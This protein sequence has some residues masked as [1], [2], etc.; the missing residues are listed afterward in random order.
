ML[1]KVQVAGYLSV[2]VRR[3]D[4]L[5]RADPAFPAPRLLSPG[6]ARWRRVDIDRWV[7]GLRA[8]WCTMGGRRAGAFGRRASQDGRDTV[9]DSTSSI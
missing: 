4:E 3:V 8:G 1:D 2:R 7:E 5:R 9:T 6:V